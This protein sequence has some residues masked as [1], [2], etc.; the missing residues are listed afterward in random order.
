MELH[1]L[2]VL[3]T[4]VVVVANGV[5]IVMDN[6][7]PNSDIFSAEP[8]TTG[9]AEVSPD[10]HF[11]S[12]E[13]RETI[14]A[15]LNVTAA[16]IGGKTLQAFS[17]AQARGKRLEIT[18]VITNGGQTTTLSPG[19]LI[20]ATPIKSLGNEKQNPIQFTFEFGDVL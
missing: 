12:W 13:R 14:K 11:N 2:S 18:V 7:D 5:P 9:G 17:N 4:S 19:V 15:T 16:S 1:S 20:S 10:G 8:R 6:F 3:D